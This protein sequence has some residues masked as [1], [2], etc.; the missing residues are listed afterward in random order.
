MSRSLKKIEFETEGPYGSVD[1]EFLYIK[2]NNSM[3]ITTIY[4]ERGNHLFSYSDD[5][6]FGMD[7]ALIVALSNWQDERMITVSNQEWKDIIETK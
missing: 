4:D 6:E 3:D 5:H 7:D 2:S 1:K